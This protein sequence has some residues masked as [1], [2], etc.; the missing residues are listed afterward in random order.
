MDLKEI[1][2]VRIDAVQPVAAREFVLH[3]S[4]IRYWCVRAFKANTLFLPLTIDPL[5]DAR[6]MLSRPSVAVSVSYGRLML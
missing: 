3:V 1:S 2:G 6:L 5:T 4:K